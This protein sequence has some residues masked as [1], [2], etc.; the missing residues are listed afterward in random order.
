MTNLQFYADGGGEPGDLNLSG[1][2]DRTSAFKSR[3]P[4]PLI[5]LVV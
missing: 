2:D 3:I 5:W 1:S 4:L